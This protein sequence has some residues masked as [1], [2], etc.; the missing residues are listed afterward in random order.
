MSSSDGKKLF[1]IGQQLR[2]EL[3]R[4]DVNSH[5]WLSYLS[6]ISAECVD[7]SPDGRWVAYV[8]FPEGALWRSTIDGS[9][10]RRLTRPP[11]QI[12]H[13]YWSPDATH[14][15]FMGIAPGSPTRVYMVPSQGGTPE[16]LLNEPYNQE[17]PSWSADGN[18]LI[19]SYLNWLEAAPRGITLLDLRTRRAVRL[20][21]SEGLWEAAWSPDGRYIVARTWDSHA[22]MLFDFNSQ[23][24]KELVKRYWLAEVVFRWTPRLLLSN[25]NRGYRDACACK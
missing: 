2:G 8:S 7:F 10:R 13:P 12:F 6:G 21:R 5:Q 22:L 16:P 25:R 15:A 24:W 19:F 9:D 17:H 14:I 3:V 11:M 1:I 4:Y 18:S 23:R 20:P